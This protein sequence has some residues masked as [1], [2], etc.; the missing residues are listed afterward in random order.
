MKRRELHECNSNTEIAEVNVPEK[1]CRFLQ[2]QNLSF[3]HMMQQQKSSN[4]D[5]MFTELLS[6]KDSAS[7]EISYYAWQYSSLFIGSISSCPKQS[8]AFLQV[9]QC[10]QQLCKRREIFFPWNVYCSNSLALIDLMECNALFTLRKI[11]ILH[12]QNFYSIRWNGTNDKVGVSVTGS[13]KADCNNFA[14][15]LNKF[16]SVNLVLL[17]LIFCCYIVLA[18]YKM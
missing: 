15:F 12:P 7:N 17:L 14:V 11:K 4:S 8:I 10:E 5:T 9:I 6:K 3:W 13:T 18:K 2:N 1:L 16:N